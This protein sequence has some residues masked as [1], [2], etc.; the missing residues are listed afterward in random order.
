MIR[1]S[2][3]RLNC[4]LNDKKNI[5]RK[6]LTHRIPVLLLPVFL[7][8]S[9]QATYADIALPTSA[10]IDVFSD[11][12]D[13]GYGVMQMTINLDIKD[14]P[15]GLAG[16]GVNELDIGTVKFDAKGLIY[17]R[18][19]KDGNRF[20]YSY[21]MGTVAGKLKKNQFSTGL[22]NY[23]NSYD[24]S[25]YFF[26]YRPAYSGDIYKSSGGGLDIKYAYTLHWLFFY[27]SGGYTINVTGNANANYG[28]DESSTGVAFK[29]TAIIQPTW[30]VTP[31]LALTF[32]AGA[33]AFAEVDFN[34][35][36]NKV[37]SDDYDAAISANFKPVQAIY[38]YDISIKRIFS[39][40]DSFNLSTTLA[41]NS[42]QGE[43]LR[44]I[45]VRYQLPFD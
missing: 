45:I 8:V 44:E 32:Y 25:G 36:E 38:G 16:A 43:D 20:E 42:D 7:L 9:A 19:V 37:D 5:N 34:S 18:A 33:A 30:Y 12:D 4:T 17:T 28:Y 15:E 11:V 23:N 1:K 27:I 26:G 29:P 6:V 14:D 13:K 24:E 35:Y 41:T 39:E 3:K 40:N 31:N 2:A 22:G 10:P 21:T